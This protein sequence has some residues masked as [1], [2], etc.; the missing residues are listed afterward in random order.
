MTVPSILSR[1]S[2]VV[3]EFST[4]QINQ[5]YRGLYTRAQDALPTQTRDAVN[6]QTNIQIDSHPSN[7]ILFDPFGDNDEEPQR[8]GTPPPSYDS[9]SCLPTYGEHVY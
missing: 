5:H 7:N 3:G 6:S 4:Q 2:S 8:M 9:A 1:I